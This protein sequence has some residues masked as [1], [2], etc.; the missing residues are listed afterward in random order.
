MRHDHVT[1][2]EEREKKL[3]YIV[4]ATGRLGYDVETY[5]SFVILKDNLKKKN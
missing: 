2:G 1:K 4:K 3:F 5:R